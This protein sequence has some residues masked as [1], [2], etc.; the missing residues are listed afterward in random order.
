MN[1][2]KISDN[3][4][5][6]Q[7]SICSQLEELDSGFS[8]KEDVWLREDGG[9]G[10]TRTG[11][12]GKIIE[13]GGVAF[14]EVFGEVS[15]SMKD[16]LKMEGNSFFACGVSIVLHP[17]HPLH[18]IIHMNIRYF[19]LDEK[20]YW[21]GG[22]I[23]LT[24]HYIDLNQAKCFHLQ[25]KEYCDLHD[26]GFYMKFKE[27]ADEYFYLPHRGESRGIGGV[28]F[29]H[30]NEEKCKLNKEEIFNFCYGLGTLF[31]SLYRFQ[32]E[33]CGSLKEPTINQLNWQ[34][35]RRGRY[36]EFNLLHDRG[37]KFGIYSGGRTESILL[38][39]PPQANWEYSLQPSPNSKESKTQAILKRK[40]NWCN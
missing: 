8:F 30:L 21:F 33:N 12:N 35:T 7:L 27:W 15:S 2:K 5:S 37:T 29:D 11:K 20:T 3:F 23:D 4:R 32:I 22:G 40:M 36:V 28:F 25:L 1:K 17:L 14:S 9:G 6:L 10:K 24:P 26:K 34:R 13:K 31:P 16:Q 18:P 38:S 19:E 39:M